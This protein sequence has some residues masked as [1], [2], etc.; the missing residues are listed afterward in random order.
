MQALSSILAGVL[1][2]LGLEAPTAGW[3][4]VE[5]WPRL[6]GERVARHSRAVSFR[7]GT[8]RVEVEGSAWMQE[9]GLLKRDLV[10]R[11]NEQLGTTAVRDVHFVVPRG[12]NLR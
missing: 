9:L 7:D 10:R 12:G 2:K 8:L 5:E 4:A 6:V 3:K 1:R 11:I